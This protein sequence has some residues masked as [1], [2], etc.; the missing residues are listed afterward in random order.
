M[1]QQRR[2]LDQDDEIGEPDVFEYVALLLGDR[3]VG[4]VVTDPP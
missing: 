4:H 1:V 2:I 3:I